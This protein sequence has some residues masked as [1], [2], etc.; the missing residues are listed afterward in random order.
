MP[1]Q[2]CK[3]LQ[4]PECCT[5]YVTVTMA[6]STTIR[7]GKRVTTTRYALL[8]PV[9]HGS[10]AFRDTIPLLLVEQPE[11]DKRQAKLWRGIWIQAISYRSR[12]LDTS[13]ICALLTHLT[14]RKFCSFFLCFIM[15]FVR[16][17]MTHVAPTKRQF[18]HPLANTRLHP[19]K[20]T[21]YCTA[22]KTKSGSRQED[23]KEPLA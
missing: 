6:Q 14:K 9:V 21:C 12:C 13:P 23:S 5:V 20:P 4:M 15:R 22:M 16:E 11:E 1:Q 8:L 17:A 7:D 18:C 19:R 2:P 3:Y 10:C